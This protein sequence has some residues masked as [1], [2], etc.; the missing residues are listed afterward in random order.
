MTK[1][2]AKALLAKGRALQD[3]LRPRVEAMLRPHSD[4]DQGAADERAKI[5]T[6]L[7]ETAERLIREAAG[8]IFIDGLASA[9]E[10]GDHL[11]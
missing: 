5:T 7:R 6:W 4:Y 8:P 2:E 9:I 3:K 11:K 10:R 1:D